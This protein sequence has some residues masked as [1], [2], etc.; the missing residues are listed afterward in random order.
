MTTDLESRLSQTL[1][2]RAAE[3]MDATDTSAELQELEGR[4]AHQHTPARAVLSSVRP[5]RSRQRRWCWGWPGS[6]ARVAT[7]TEAPSTIG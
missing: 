1:Q 6:P 3:A 5:L 4:L 2:G 7:L